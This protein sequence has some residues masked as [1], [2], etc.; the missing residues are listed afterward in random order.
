MLIKTMEA[1]FIM[2]LSEYGG[3]CVIDNDG[4]G[5]SDTDEIFGGT[6]VTACNYNPDATEDIGSCVFAETYYDCEGNCLIDSDE[7]GVC[8]ELETNGC[9]DEASCTYNFD[10][11]E[12]DGSL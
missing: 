4:D 12:D 3:D 5:I 11:T 2:M 9:T 6:Y 1:A 10:A 8:D 7:D